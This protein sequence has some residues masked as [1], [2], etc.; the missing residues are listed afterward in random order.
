MLDFQTGYNV[1]ALDQIGYDEKLKDHQDLD[2]T[3]YTLQS[4]LPYLVQTKE[5]EHFGTLHEKAF[6]RLMEQLPNLQSLRLRKLN[7]HGPANLLGH[8]E[9][10]TRPLRLDRLDR[11]SRLTTIEIAQLSNPEVEGLAGV[12]RESDCLQSLNLTA[13]SKARVAITN[14]SY[15]HDHKLQPMVYF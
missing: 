13:A 1:G 15:G 4:L 7:A 10:E 8:Y 2:D 12:I 5:L 6:S 3:L 11:F 14:Q 9:P